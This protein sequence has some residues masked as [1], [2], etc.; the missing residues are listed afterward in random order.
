[1]NLRRNKYV[2]FLLLM[3][4]CISSCK[5]RFNKEKWVNDDLGGDQRNDMLDDLVA[6]HKIIGLK[7]SQLIDSFGEPVHTEDSS[8]V[9]YTILENYDI[10]DPISGKDLVIKLN[11]DSIVTG[12]YIN[13]WKRK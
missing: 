9:F 11:R 13:N 3:I 2:I 12:F 7:Y 8:E 5:T 4:F 1:M 6:N 10:I